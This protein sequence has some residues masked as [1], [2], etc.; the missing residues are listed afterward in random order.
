MNV[1]IFVKEFP[2]DVIGGAE[3]QS[4]RHARELQRREGYEVTVYT[5]SY[6]TSTELETEYDIVR[7]PT[8]H[9][10]RFI[11]TL[12]FLLF[13]VVVLLRD[14][15]KLDV[16]QC[17]MIYPNGFVG[18]LLNSL[19]GLPYFAWIRGGDYYFMK[20]HRLKRRMIR[21]VLDDSL[22]LTVSDGVIDDVLEEFPDAKL[23]SIHNGVDIPDD[24]ADGDEIVF[25]GRL[26][27]QKGVHVL[28]EAVR[29]LDERLLIVGDGPERD[30]LERT[31]GKT[32][33]EATFVGE[34]PPEEVEQYLRRGKLFVLPSVRGEGGSPNAMLEA[35]AVGL[36]VVVTRTGGMIDAVES[37]NV[38]FLVEP[39]DV[40]ALRDRIQRLCSDEQLR[41]DMA[42]N[43]REYVHRTHGWETI[44]EQLTDVYEEV[45]AEQRSS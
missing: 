5:K 20:E 38:G 36:P 23:R 39:G 33:V 14:S 42:T 13:S 17:M 24:T 3:V 19:T 15:R 28:I 18:H 12:T 2:P 7:I 26:K 6:S 27:E 44:I 45:I 16:L 34:V 41:Q 10:N 37:E 31:V 9:L 32:D 8:W 1:G 29:G 22:T 11:S 35:M 25:V 21:R 4:R 30:R 43:A 40:D